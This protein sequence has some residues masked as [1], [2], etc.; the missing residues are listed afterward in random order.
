MVCD[1]GEF[2]LRVV[3]FVLLVFAV[4]VGGVFEIVCWYFLFCFV[5]C[6]ARGAGDFS[7]L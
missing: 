1:C 7:V 3:L 6:L 2:V 4:V 5:D